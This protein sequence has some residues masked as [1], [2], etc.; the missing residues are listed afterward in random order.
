MNLKT[1][2]TILLLSITTGMSCSTVVRYMEY[3]EVIE[4]DIL[5]YVEYVNSLTNDFKSVKSVTFY[6]QEPQP[7]KEAFTIGYC[8][9]NTLHWL[10]YVKINKYFW[11]VATQEEKILLIAHELKH[12]SCQSNWKHINSKDSENC[13]LN[14]M[15]SMLPSSYC[16][17]KHFRTYLEQIR[18]GCNDK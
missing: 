18:R 3:K 12:C 17:S 6:Y 15:E 10:H 2:L 9:Y 7:K 13:A 5:P 11:Q 8:S 4:P 14:Y 16:I 1:L